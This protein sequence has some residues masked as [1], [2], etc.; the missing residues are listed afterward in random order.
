MVKVITVA[1]L[2]GGVSKSTT[3]RH[4]SLALPQCALIDLDPQGTTRRFIE[5]REK[6]GRKAPIGIQANHDNLADAIELAKTQG[7]CRYILID[8]PPAHT[9]KRQLKSAVT[10]SDYIL[11]PSKYSIDDLEIVPMVSQFVSENGNAPMG[12]FLTMT[13]KVKA[14]NNARAFLAK[15]AEKFGADVWDGEI[16]DRVAYVESAG[17]SQSVF[18]YNPKGEAAKEMQALCDWVLNNMKKSEVSNNG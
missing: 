18:E 4:L 12:Y 9:D 3:A 17:L 7:N 15:C 1:S 14:M 16:K 10:L 13:R 8:T 2:K 6:R 5:R 11:V